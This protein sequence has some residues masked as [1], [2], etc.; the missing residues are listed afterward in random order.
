MHSCRL[1]N[2]N[3]LA[4]LLLAENGG[5]ISHFWPT[6][7]FRGR[8]GKISQSILPVRLRTKP[9]NTFF[10]LTKPSEEGRRGRVGGGRDNVILSCSLPITLLCDVGKCD[11]NA[12]LRYMVYGPLLTK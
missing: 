10:T 12:I 7:K 5:Q 9:F 4:C 3:I 1:L 6:V 11:K 2:N 8:M